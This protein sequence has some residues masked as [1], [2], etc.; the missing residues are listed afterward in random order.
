[1]KRYTLLK[2]AVQ[3]LEAIAFQ[4]NTRLLDQLSIA[5]NGVRVELAKGTPKIDL[6]KIDKIIKVHTN[7]NI[8]TSIAKGTMDAHIAVMPLTRYSPMMLT[9]MKQALGDANPANALRLSARV[10]TVDLR[11][12]RVDGIFAA[13]APTILSVGVEIFKRP[14]LTDHEVSAII[15][16]EVGHLFAYYYML[17]K[18]YRTDYIL[19]QLARLGDYDRSV[20]IEFLDTVADLTQLDIKSAEVNT[21]DLS[22][23]V[24]ANN[25]QTI[26]RELGTKYLD[27]QM[28]EVVADQYATRF[29]AGVHLTVALDKIGRDEFFLW[30]HDQ[31][32]NTGEAIAG[33][34]LSTIFTLFPLGAPSVGKALMSIVKQPLVIWPRQLAFLMVGQSLVTSWKLIFRSTSNMDP[35]E[36]YTRIRN[37]MMNV[38]KSPDIPREVV[39]STLY[40]IDQMNRFIKDLSGLKSL[41]VLVGEAMY[42][43]ISGKK[44]STAYLE[45]LETLA[46]NDLFQ[47]A[48]AFRLKDEPHVS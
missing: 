28:T 23:Q 45:R 2:D 6:T 12:G 8:L 14:L 47:H 11:T 37:D 9:P 21:A 16:H 10:G 46:N 7:L 41:S 25:V 5:V 20:Q 32:R 30:K 35:T 18:N 44:Q 42:G 15:L 29:G 48:A 4:N 13:T 39:S 36:R 19:D 26:Q 43:Y 34:S 27:G 38:L 33:V 1:M 40:D 17:S 24:V 22:V 31:Y 3:S